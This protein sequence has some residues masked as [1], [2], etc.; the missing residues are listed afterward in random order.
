MALVRGEWR[1]KAEEDF[2]FP[3]RWREWLWDCQ[4]VKWSSA[5][6]GERALRSWLNSAVADCGCRDR[7]TGPGRGRE[8]WRK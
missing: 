6:F 2:R 3:K 8:R 4:L 5:H 7:G 1:M